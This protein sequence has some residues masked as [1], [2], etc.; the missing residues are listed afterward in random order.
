MAV[1][2]LVLALIVT[3]AVLALAAAGRSDRG[4]TRRD[5]SQHECRDRLR[6]LGF[7]T[8]HEYRRSELWRE[9]KR[10]YRRSDYPQ[11]CIVCGTTR[12]DLHH[13]S[14]A[15]LGDEEL[16]DLVP[17]CRRRHDQLHQLLD[18]DP[19]ACVKDTH[20]F[21]ALIM[22][23]DTPANHREAAPIKQKRRRAGKRWLP[24]ED[25]EL[26]EKFDLGIPI[27]QLALRL[28]RGVRAVEVRLFKLGRHSFN[29]WKDRDAKHDTSPDL[30]LTD[31]DVER[32]K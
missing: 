18:Q 5:V 11:R 4:C 25:A 12:F 15:R 22:E 10:R 26:L 2:V 3:A 24:D 23:H 14:Y 1:S 32:R 6:R 28:N 27:K 7:Q 16:F 31:T 13:R 9:N 8:L 29:D 21:V 30:N 17:L 20:D 19:K